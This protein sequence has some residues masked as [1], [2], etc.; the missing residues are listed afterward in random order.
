MCVIDK[1]TLSG[2]CL[3]ITSSKV[4]LQ[5]NQIEDQY[6]LVEATQLQYGRLSSGG[7]QS[8]TVGDGV[9]GRDAIGKRETTHCV[10]KLGMCVTILN[11]K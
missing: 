7:S 3:P 4:C 5:W 9:L 8:H 11:G 6:D 2:Q 10:D 1:T